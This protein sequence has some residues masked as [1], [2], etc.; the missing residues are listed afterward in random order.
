MGSILRLLIFYLLRCYCSHVLH[1]VGFIGLLEGLTCHFTLTLKGF[2]FTTAEALLPCVDSPDEQFQVIF[3]EIGQVAAIFAADDLAHALVIPVAFLGDHGGNGNVAEEVVSTAQQHSGGHHPRQSLVPLGERPRHQQ[4]GLSHRCLDQRMHVGLLQKLVV[5]SHSV[6]QAVGR[7]HFVGLV[8][9]GGNGMLVSLPVI[10]CAVVH[11][12]CQ[13]E[14]HRADKVLIQRAVQH[15]DHL[16]PRMAV[17]P[18]HLLLDALRF[19]AALEEI[20]GLLKWY[21]CTLHKAGK[22]HLLRHGAGHACAVWVEFRVLSER[23]LAEPFACR[24]HPVREHIPVGHSGGI[25]KREHGSPGLAPVEQLRPETVDGDVQ[26]QLEKHL[27]PRKI[28]R[29]KE[30][31]QFFPVHCHLQLPP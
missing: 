16:R 18:D 21:L 5:F 3:N 9:H 4:K 31:Q 8:V 23:F 14:G 2:L 7:R 13:H 29:L 1:R 15:P 24:H 28:M 26:R 20:H 17:V 10:L 30:S 6:G 25:A 22:E 19:R 11:L 12:F 27:L